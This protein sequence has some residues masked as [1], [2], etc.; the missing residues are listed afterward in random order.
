[1]GGTREGSWSGGIAQMAMK[2]FSMSASRA[3]AEAVYKGGE[4]DVDEEWVT[5]GAK[6]PNFRDSQSLLAYGVAPAA[7][8]RSS[9]TLASTLSF[10]L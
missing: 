8:G 5:C 2:S 1:M 7:P 4:K 10:S 3:V 6:G 9:G